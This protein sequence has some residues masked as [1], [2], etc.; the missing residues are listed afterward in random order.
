MLALADALNIMEARDQRGKPV[1]FSIAF[2]KKSTGEL[3][4]VPSAHKPT[5]SPRADAR[6]K[7]A[8]ENVPQYDSR[9][10]NHY[11]NQTRN[12][13]VAGTSQIRKVCIRLITEVNGHKI[14][15]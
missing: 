12:I 8:L 10:P 5:L 2:V 14:F 15:Y 1:L 11:L 9:N 7:A 4:R 13:Q 6:A 3:I